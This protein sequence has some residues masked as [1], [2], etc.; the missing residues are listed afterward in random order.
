M[1]ER[2]DA[3]VVLGGL[4]ILAWAWL[5]A[6]R[7]A[8][9]VSP[10]LLVWIGFLLLSLAT[11]AAGRASFGAEAVVN[12]R[13]RVYSEM[14]ALITT[15]ALL[16]RLGPRKGAWLLTVLLPLAAVWFWS[17]WTNNLPFI[18]D[19]AIRQRNSLDHYLLT[20]H[21]DYGGFPSQDFGDF[22][23]TRTGVAGDFLPH[24]EDG[25]PGVLL[26]TATPASAVAATDFWADAPFTYAGAVSVHGFAP[27]GKRPLAL[28][29]EDG[30]RRYQGELRTQRMFD[31]P[32]S[33]DRTMFW[34]TFSLGGLVPGRYRVGYAIGDPASARVVWTD[35]WIDVK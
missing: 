21:G 2:F 27:A 3:A 1:A 24:S 32:A 19:I 13:Y 6:T 4:L 12:S 31:A 34:N 22:M 35:G 9:A 17:S 10:L 26:E 18:A 33:R 7:R 15:I 5:V 20:R 28:R 11:I 25:P 14:A 16:Q 8:G 23:L 30:T 29:L